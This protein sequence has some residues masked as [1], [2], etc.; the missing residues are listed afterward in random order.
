ME[1]GSLPRN[2]E[3]KGAKACLK[4]LEYGELYV[5]GKSRRKS[6]VLVTFGSGECEVKCADGRAR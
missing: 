4:R 5:G 2:H 6:R 3:R 1:W